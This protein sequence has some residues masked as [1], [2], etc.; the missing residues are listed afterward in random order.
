VSALFYLAFFGTVIAFGCYLKLISLIGMEKGA[1]VMLIC[2]VV[3]LGLSIV[4]EGYHWRS[5]TIVAVIL[6]LL[7]NFMVLV[8]PKQKHSTLNNASL[9]QQGDKKRI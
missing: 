7:G 1:Y 4:F 9:T 8:K 3:A 5:S 2:P 6:V